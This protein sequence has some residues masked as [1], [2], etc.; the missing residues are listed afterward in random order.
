MWERERGGG[1]FRRRCILT[2]IRWW[3]EALYVHTYVVVPTNPFLFSLLMLTSLLR[4]HV[5]DQDREGKRASR[6]GLAD[7]G[8]AKRENEY[9]LFGGASNRTEERRR[10]RNTRE[11]GERRWSAEE[12]AERGREERKGGIKREMEVSLLLPDV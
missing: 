4:K 12:A 3:C 11:G 5:F 9:S 1:G 6:A 7:M 2:N 10:E 8:G